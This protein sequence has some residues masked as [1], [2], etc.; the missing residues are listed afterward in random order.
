MKRFLMRELLEP[1]NLKEPSWYNLCTWLIITYTIKISRV[2]HKYGWL[3]GCLWSS[4][5]CP[6][7]MEGLL[8]Y[9]A[10]HLTI[11]QA[12]FPVYF[13]FY[14][15][16]CLY[17]LSTDLTE[18]LWSLTE[19]TTCCFEIIEDSYLVSFLSNIPSTPFKSCSALPP[20]LRLVCKYASSVKPLKL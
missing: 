12:L 3:H 14:Q 17:L 11:G 15:V 20:A 4:M 8:F 18:G 2:M 10:V 9:L 1:E 7:V 13:S 19:M 16:A 5:L 6:S